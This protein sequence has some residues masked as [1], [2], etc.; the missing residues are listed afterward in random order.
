MCAVSHGGITWTFRRCRIGIAKLANALNSKSDEI[1]SYRII[2]IV[3][4]RTTA[5]QNE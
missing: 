3:H 1:P 4:E 2:A 5:T